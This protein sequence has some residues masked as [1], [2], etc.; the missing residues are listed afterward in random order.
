MRRLPHR[1][2]SA[3]ALIVL[4]GP[5]FVAMAQEP[6][7]SREESD[8]RL[9]EMTRIVREI[10][11]SRDEGSMRRAVELKPEPL[12]RWNDP[13]RSLS[14]G[15][16]WA[17]G[18]TG[19]PIAISTLEYYPRY[20]F[21]GA[22]P[23]PIWSIELVSTAPPATAVEARTIENA[24]GFASFKWTPRSPGMELKPIP[25][26]ALPAA[27]EAE[28][29]RQGRAIAAR[30]S[31]EEVHNGKYVLRLM[32]RPIYRYSDADASILDGAIFLF[33][34]GTNPEVLLFL[35]AAGKESP[36]QWSYGLA[37][38]TRSAYEV[39][40]DG[41]TVWSQEYAAEATETTPYYFGKAR[42]QVP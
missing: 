16:L 8:A 11:M 42:R 30:F 3:W 9:E 40:I 26:A 7:P 10:S 35:E 25:G 17:W 29:L 31:A 23:V 5:G 6:T 33:A 41:E 18:R 34:N 1:R 27:T 32:P 28:R 14:D 22:A 4:T 39:R 36:A 12:H 38:L 2:Y 20:S 15:L 24:Q 13:T 21:A 19:R 37:R